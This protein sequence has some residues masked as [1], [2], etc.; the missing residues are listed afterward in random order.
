MINS[1][2]SSNSRI[3]VHRK[4]YVPSLGSGDF[5]AFLDDQDIASC[6]QSADQIEAP[7]QLR[8]PIMHRAETGRLFRVR[9][10]ARRATVFDSPFLPNEPEVCSRS[11]PQ[12]PT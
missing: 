1:S 8:M 9:I 4:L 7:P 10:E 11:S 6:R 12:R 5:V 3:E 2:L